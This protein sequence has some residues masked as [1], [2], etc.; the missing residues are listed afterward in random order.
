M[1]DN[2]Q[3]SIKEALHFLEESGLVTLALGNV[4]SEYENN[5]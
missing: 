4:I 2:E 5:S 1:T 3:N